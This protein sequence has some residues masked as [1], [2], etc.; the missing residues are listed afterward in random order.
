ML[1]ILGKQKKQQQ[2]QQAASRVEESEGRAMSSDEDWETDPDFVSGPPR[3]YMCAGEGAATKALYR[4]R[5]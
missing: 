3:E 5:A 1:E 4:G 2:Q